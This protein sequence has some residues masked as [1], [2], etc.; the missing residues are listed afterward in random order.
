M[1]DVWVRARRRFGVSKS[2]YDGGHKRSRYVGELS[3]K[4]P[5]VS[6]SAA[7]H[8]SHRQ[9]RLAPG[10]LPRRSEPARQ[11]PGARVRL[12]PLAALVAA[13]LT[14]RALEKF[15]TEQVSVAPT[16]DLEPV[17]QDYIEA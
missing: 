17:G 7:A 14:P 2:A 3:A 6:L 4:W 1:I 5:S 15:H 8:S 12:S 13:R 10:N 9:A 11:L 16:G